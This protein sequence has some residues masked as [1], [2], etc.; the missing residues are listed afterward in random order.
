MRH[1]IQEFVT[2]GGIDDFSLLKI[3]MP[4]KEFLEVPSPSSKDAEDQ[5]VKEEFIE[6]HAEG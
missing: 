3:K 5:L 1:K 2:R 4:L 6:I